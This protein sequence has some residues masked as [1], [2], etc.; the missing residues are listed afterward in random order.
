MCCDSAGNAT[1][2]VPGHIALVTRYVTPARV[3]LNLVA[4]SPG[5]VLA[6]T[7]ATT[8]AVQP[9]PPARPLGHPVG[10]PPRHPT[11]RLIAQDRAGAPSRR[12]RVL[13][14]WCSVLPEVPGMRPY[15]VY[16]DDA[17]RSAIPEHPAITML[18]AKPHAESDSHPIVP[19]DRGCVR[20]K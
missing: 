6:A 2:T 16:T 14:R 8:C 1:R 5:V 19:A 15:M 7:I 18:G 9:L 17:L 10:L 11:T 3:R 13:H 4:R 12:L 20:D